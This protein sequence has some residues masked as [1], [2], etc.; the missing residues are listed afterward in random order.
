MSADFLIELGTEELPPKALLSLSNAFTSGIVDGFRAE[1]LSFGEVTSY[2]AP[3][4]L[5]V[6]I[7]G[8]DTQA[9]DAEI[10]V[11]G[12]PVKVAFDADGQP[13]KAAVAF[14]KKNQIQLADLASYLEN[15]GQQDKLCVR[16]T[17]TGAETR[18]LLAEVINNSL[19][20][21]PIPK[22]MRWG[23]SKEEF[24]RPVQWAV[25]L[26][27]GQVCEERILGIQASN[28]SRGH[29]FHSEGDIS[30]ESPASY[31]QQLESAHVIADFAKRREIIRAGVT[32]LAEKIKGK[33]IIDEDLLDEVSAL[34]E[35]PVPLMGRFDEH[36]LS[37]PAQALVSSMKEH[38]KYFHVVG[39]DNNLLA[40]FI[41]VANIESTDPAQIIDGNERVIRPRLADAAFFYENDKKNSL[42]SRREALKK[43]VFQAE[44]GSV[45]E[46]TERVAV[47]AETLA[48]VT[49]ADASLARRAAEL[50]KSDLVTDMVG[51]FDDLQGTMG[52]DYAL[53]DGEHAEVAEAQYEQY[54]PRF[55]GDSVPSTATGA[56]LALA[57]RLDS[58]VGI[59]SIGQ[60]PS[61]SR[62]PFALR[63]A[64][65]G[66]LRIIIERNVD[67]DLRS[68]I[69]K[70]AEAFSQNS[71]AKLSSNEICESVLTYILERFKY[72]FKEEGIQSE[73]FLAVSS[74]GLSNPLDINA[75]VQAVHQFSLLPEAAALA[76]ANKR[77]SNILAKQLGDQTPAAVNTSLLQDDAENKLASQIA[78]LTQLVAPLIEQRDYNAVL[79]QLASL[80][81]AV[82]RF[83][84]DVMVMTDDRALRENRLALL[85]SLHSLFI[86]VADISQLAPA[87]K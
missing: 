35:W 64:S 49:G 41:T 40:A 63:R 42:E 23:S 26:F 32:R 39:S 62:D 33:A 44:L 22:R 68:A 56:T 45:Y 50:S 11:W 21:L 30:I 28:V 57:D 9:P 18:Q 78:A 16:R 51:E 6:V 36:F 48:S 61:G 52:R 69:A 38:Q 47:L 29:R 43:V 59:F 67:V 24:V 34:N 71:S 60:Q 37:V 17:E 20:A 10:V 84:E 74:L 55:S 85:H 73:V 4:R 77:V 25:L 7:N 54:L 80:R 19:A 46:K 1:K 3:R 27:D 79:S 83:F 75:R 82:D 15:D 2:A 8:L 13:T 72:W 70:A 31:E 53:N 86:N 87:N 76:S 14:A 58:L 81:E 66:I 65:L 5:A 12:P